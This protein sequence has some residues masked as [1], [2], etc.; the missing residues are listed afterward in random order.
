MLVVA[1]REQLAWRP[2]DLPGQDSRHGP[3]VCRRA[4]DAGRR[5][6]PDANPGRNRFA[7]A[8]GSLDQPAAL[9]IIADVHQP[10]RP[11]DLDGHRGARSEGG[12]LSCLRAVISQVKQGA[13]SGGV[14]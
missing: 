1:E 13:E 4:D 3:V 7:G 12:L 10:F 6:F 9:A 11:D 14:S 5:R 8:G 2:R